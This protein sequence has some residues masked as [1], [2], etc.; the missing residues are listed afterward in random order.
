MRAAKDLVFAFLAGMLMVG[1]GMF[2][3]WEV[4]PG[5]WSEFARANTAMFSLLAGGLTI[6]IRR[7]L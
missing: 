6:A 3:T 7:G 5:E 4:N 1:F 2:I